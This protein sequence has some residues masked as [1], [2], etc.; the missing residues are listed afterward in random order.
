MTGTQPRPP[1]QG[2]DRRTLVVAGV[3][4]LGMIM[5]VLDTTIVNVALDKLSQDLNSPLGTIQWVST[6]YLLALA[7]VIPLAGWLSE[8]FGSK[9]I[10]MMSVAGFGLGSALCGLAWSDVSLIAFRI[11]QGFGGGLIMPVGQSVLAQTA[12]PNRMG[13]VM[14]VIGVPILLAPILG[15]VIGGVIVDSGSW[16]WLF[17]VNV[18]IAVA[19][20]AL[21]H[22]ILDRDLARADAGRLDWVGV[23][24]LS[25]GLAA[26]VF[27]LSQ[28]E[29]SGG[30]GAPTALGPIIA[31]ALLV[32]LFV[33]HALRAAR[34]LVDIRLF[35]SRHFS[36]AAATTFLLG[37]ALFGAMLVLP[38]YYQVA[39]GEA[40]LT[41]GLLMAPQGIGAALAMPF[42]G[43]LVDRVGGGHVAIVGCTIMTLAT[44]PLAFVGAHTSFALLAAVL[45]VRGV[46][47]GTAMMPSMAA[48]YAPLDRA[49]VPRATGVLTTLQRIGGSIGTTLLAVILEQ[50]AGAATGSAAAGSSG[51]Q[52]VTPAVRAQL[53]DPLAA[54]FGHTFAWAAAITAAAMIPAALLAW[55]EWSGRTSRGARSRRRGWRRPG[56]RQELASYD[57]E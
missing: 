44:V 14:S 19:A 41:A 40:A 28:M 24:L 31:G 26:I 43:R 55:T 13:R 10:W 2:L 47:L 9:R 57:R 53:A 34:P 20:L 45:V 12:G 42:S 37:A 50:Q 32:A 38:L 33:R 54:A 22:R 4:I 56:R 35:G 36:A 16:R 39:R 49:Q 25:P 30:I 8:R 11:L 15:P 23:A 51:L 52:P 18:P 5:S 17:F 7:M 3:V 48:A 21:A 29:S 6:G 1:G 46:G 27:G